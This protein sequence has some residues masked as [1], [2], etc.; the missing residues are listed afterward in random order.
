MQRFWLFLV[1]I[2][3]SFSCGQGQTLTQRDTLY[4]RYTTMINYQ[5]EDWDTVFVQ[6]WRGESLVATI[7]MAHLAGRWWGNYY[8]EG[9]KSGSYSIEY[10][11]VYEGDT[12]GEFYPMSILDTT[13]FHGN[14]ADTVAIKTWWTN[15]YDRDSNNWIDTTGYVMDGAVSVSCAGTGIRTVMVNIKNDAD[16]TGIAN[17]KVVVYDSTGGGFIASGLTT[18]SGLFTFYPDDGVCKIFLSMPGWITTSPVYPHISGNTSLTY[19]ATLFTPSPPPPGDSL[20]IVYGYVYHKDA[21]PYPNARVR[22]WADYTGVTYHGALIDMKTPAIAYTD[23]S[24]YFEF[25]ETK[26]NIKGIYPN[27]VLWY[28]G[29]NNTMWWIEV[30]GTNGNKIYEHWFE[31]PVGANYDIG[32]IFEK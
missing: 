4:L 31:V 18:A 21:T 5:L 32:N 13:A 12:T 22:I 7:G 30:T 19:Y 14:G 15:H 17:F 26:S 24:G 8:L 27:D 1:A 28:N 9:L 10:F 23:A 3:L 11:A 2:F 16:S 6:L 29:K 20:C 25:S